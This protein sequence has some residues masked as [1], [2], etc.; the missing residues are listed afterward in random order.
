MRTADHTAYSWHVPINKIWRWTVITS[1][2]W[3]WQSNG[4]KP[5]WLQLPQNEMKY[6]KCFMPKTNTDVGWL[7]QPPFIYL[8][9]KSYQG[10]RKNEK[11]C[12]KNT[13]TQNARDRER[14][15]QKNKQTKENTQ[16]TTSQKTPNK[17]H[18]TKNISNGA[19]VVHNV[20]MSRDKPVMLESLAPHLSEETMNRQADLVWGLEDTFIRVNFHSNSLMISGT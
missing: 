6:N 1:Q 11:K 8:L 15:K 9:C 19:Y 14:E 7:W 4:W 17:K 5:Q 10:T 18:L 3:R 13:H 2:C 16:K 12:R 20:E